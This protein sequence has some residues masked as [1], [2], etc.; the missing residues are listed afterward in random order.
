MIP[1]PVYTGEVPTCTSIVHLIE[2]PLNPKEITMSDTDK[3]AAAQ[4][5]AIDTASVALREIKRQIRV[6]AKDDD[7]NAEQ[8]SPLV[9]A[10][11]SISEQLFKD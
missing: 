7:V 10:L 1:K 5:L 2:I 8:L 11:T 4:A 9:Y 6:L 3:V